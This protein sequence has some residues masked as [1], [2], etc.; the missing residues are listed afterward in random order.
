M[1]LIVGPS[2]YVG[3]SGGSFQEC[4]VDY[5]GSV[6]QKFGRYCTIKDNEKAPP[7]SRVGHK[8]VQ[9]FRTP[10]ND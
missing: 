7:T 8:W 5:L 6:D 4:S 10:D 9:I 3:R 1:A 2:E